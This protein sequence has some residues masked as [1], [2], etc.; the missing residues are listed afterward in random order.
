MSLPVVFEPAAQKDLEDLHEWIA[1]RASLATARR[2]TERLRAYC[3]S[4][5]LFPERGLRRDDIKPGLRIIGF[6]RRVNVAFVIL[7]GQVRIVRLLYGGRDIGLLTTD[8]EP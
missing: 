6:E 2:Y 7:N 8:Q 4:F 3:K 1:D 5:A